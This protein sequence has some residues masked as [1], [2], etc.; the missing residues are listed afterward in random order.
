M[1]LHTNEP[2]NE[3]I[4][5]AK[6]A[7]VGASPVAAVACV[8]AKGVVVRT[9]AALEGTITGT[10]SI[11][12]TLNGGSNIGALSIAAGGAGTG[13]TDTPSASEA[14][15]WVDEGDFITFTPSGAT[16]TSIPASFFAVV[17]RK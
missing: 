7:S 9:G 17:R 15:R 13:A 3:A 8:P 10:A 6:T 14:N 12:V 16:G 2:I 11:S 1:A 5:W 4:V